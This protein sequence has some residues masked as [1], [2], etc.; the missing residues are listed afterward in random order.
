MAF[1]GTLKMPT[2][3]VNT[4]WVFSRN[5]YILSSSSQIFLKGHHFYGGN[6]LVHSPKNIFSNWQ[7]KN[8]CCSVH[9]G[10][11]H[12]SLPGTLEAVTGGNGAISTAILHWGQFN[13]MA[14]PSPSHSS[15][16]PHLGL[17]ECSEEV[18][19]HLLFVSILFILMG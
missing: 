2:F 8:N 14:E 5:I 6:S 19:L 9:S 15:L 7:Y 13:R 3:K 18:D 12:V 11:S 1:P 17:G 4:M 16:S 10:P